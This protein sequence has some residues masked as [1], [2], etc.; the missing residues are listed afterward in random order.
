MKYL[1]LGKAMAFNYFGQF[2]LDSRLVLFWVVPDT[3]FFLSFFP[4]NLHICTYFPNKPMCLAGF[5]ASIAQH[6]YVFA[7]VES[8]IS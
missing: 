8:N 4:K 7:S 1:K 5:N 6:L 3:V 2:F